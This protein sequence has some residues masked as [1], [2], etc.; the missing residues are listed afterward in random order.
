M[1]IL[2]THQSNSIS[3]EIEENLPEHEAFEVLRA[4]TVSAFENLPDPLVY[5]LSGAAEPF[6]LQDPKDWKEGL[7]THFRG[8]VICFTVVDPSAEADSE[9]SD[10]YVHITDNGEEQAAQKADESKA[11]KPEEPIEQAN[12]EDVVIED[13]EIDSEPELEDK[14]TDE[15]EVEAKEDA[16]GDDRPHALPNPRSLCQRVKQFI[17]EIG[18]EGLQNIAAVVHTLVTEGNVNLSD[19]IRTAVETSDKAAKHPLTQDLLAIIDVYVQ[20]FNSCN[21]T[22]MLSQFN[23]D[24]IIALIPGIVDA[25]TRSMEGAQDVELDLSPIMSQ[26]CPMLARMQSCIPQGEER[27]FRADPQNP[28][29]V[30]QQAREQMEAEF[31]QQDEA[32]RHHGIHCDGCNMSPIVG[33]RYKS[34]LTADFD[35]CEDCEKEHDPK[36]PL[37]KI[38][39][40]V[41][42]MD[43][44]PGL[45]EFRRSIGGGR[46]RRCPRRG[47]RG[48]GFC[49]PRRGC[50]P[51]GRGGIPAPMRAFAE[52][53]QNHPMAAAM[54]EQ[55]QN[56]PMAAAMRERFCQPDASPADHRDP[57]RQTQEAD[58]VAVKKAEVEQKKK[59]VREAK[60]KVKALKKEMNACRKEMKHAKKAQKKTAKA[61]D[62]EVTGHLDLEEKSVQKAGAT[63]LKTW[64]VKNTGTVAWSEDTIA[65]FHSGNESLVVPGYEVIQVGALEPSDV[66]YI[67]CMLSVPEVEGT[68]SLN[69]RLSGPKGKFG[70]RLSTQVEVVAEKEIKAEETNVTFSSQP[71]KNVPKIVDLSNVADEEEEDPVVAQLVKDLPEPKPSAPAPP[72]KK[73][74]SQFSKQKDQLKL[75]GFD[76]DDETLESVLVA[77]KGDI[78]QAISLLM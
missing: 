33:V 28:C 53:M 57:A 74:P 67:R 34:V 78:G 61:L 15:E 54:R 50:R 16:E 39:T 76:M 63:V 24:Q 47:G 69:Y 31:P 66:A 46:G 30:F 42:D 72:A 38:K 11:A 60:A 7:Q 1:K 73:K 59:E 44:L 45:S 75:M 65:I 10:S 40:P 27:V 36:D 55:M 25:L 6:L 3:F 68:Y 12:A 29:S 19:A 17:V 37:I 13:Y 64:K 77:C 22:A 43:V 51:C 18:S 56:H 71:G 2:I 4:F 9:E 49:R 58:P 70:D 8:S 26:F 41:Q 32:P 23:I 21:W 62:G 14:D 20:K 35:L 48:R 5:S 52:M